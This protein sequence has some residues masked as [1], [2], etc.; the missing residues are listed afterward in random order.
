LFSEDPLCLNIVKA[1]ETFQLLIKKYF[2]T[3]INEGYLREG[4]THQYML[5]FVGII[6]HFTFHWLKQGGDSQPLSDQAGVILDIFLNG[7]RN[8]EQDSS[9]QKL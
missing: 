3:G 6:S 5:A 4:D 1:Q 9:C 8:K 7:V 2:E